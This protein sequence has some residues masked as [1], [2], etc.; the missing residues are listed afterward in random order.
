MSRRP[1][2]RRGPAAA[3][4]LCLAVGKHHLSAFLE[5]TG[6]WK[7]LL[8]KKSVALH[9]FSAHVHVSGEQTAQAGGGFSARSSC[10]GLSAHLARPHLTALPLTPAAAPRRFQ[11]PAP[12]PPGAGAA[13]PGLPVPPCR[14]RRCRRSPAGAPVPRDPHGHPRR[15]RQGAPPP[16]RSGRGSGGSP[17]SPGGARG[18]RAARSRAGSSTDL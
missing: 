18:A 13:V 1:P 14:C 7:A 17:G 3:P 6:L 11:A 10:A 2:G 15:G 4:L 16:A 5:D 12:R 9:L 8:R